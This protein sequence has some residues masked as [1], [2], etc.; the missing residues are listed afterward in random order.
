MSDHPHHPEHH[1]S[2][3]GPA[4]G[5]RDPVAVTR[6]FLA[7]ALERCDPESDAALE[8]CAAWAELDEPGVAPEQVEADIPD[9]LPPDVILG[10]ARN[11]LY[12]AIFTIIPARRVYALAWAIRHL[13]LA[14]GHL[15]RG[16]HT[17]GGGTPA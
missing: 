1:H 13:D 9:V 8:I 7:A 15:N 2:A 5:H 17:R 14:V 3:S 12:A 10:I 11:V 6:G 16:V 4:A